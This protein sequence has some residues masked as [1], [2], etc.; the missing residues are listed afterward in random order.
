MSGPYLEPDVGG[1]DDANII[2]VGWR[3]CLYDG[4]VVLLPDMG[5]AKSICEY[6]DE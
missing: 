6:D 3:R 1:D 4:T 2:A 5:Y